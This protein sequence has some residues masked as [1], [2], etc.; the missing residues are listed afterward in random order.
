MPRKK[1]LFS[2][3]QQEEERRNGEWYLKDSRDGSGKTV[4]EVADGLVFVLDSEAPEVIFHI[5]LGKEKDW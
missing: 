2:E 4:T 3:E 1:G 5:I